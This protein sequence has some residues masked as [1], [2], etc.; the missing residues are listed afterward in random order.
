MNEIDRAYRVR[1]SIGEV[2]STATNFHADAK[3]LVYQV[4]TARS[5]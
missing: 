3:L 5:P 1:I 2:S 4:F